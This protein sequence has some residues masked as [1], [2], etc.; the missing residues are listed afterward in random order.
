MTSKL[1]AENGEPKQIT[2][3]HRNARQVR[4]Q[5]AGRLDR[6]A[7]VHSDHCPHGSPAAIRK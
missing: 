3:N 5:L 2:S 1:S 7:Q 6:A 4:R